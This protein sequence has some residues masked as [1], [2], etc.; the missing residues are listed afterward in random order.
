[1]SS[2]LDNYR[3]SIIKQRWINV[4]GS[5]YASL[6][7]QYQV[8]FVIIVCLVAFISYS[9]IK[10][11]VNYD[12]G[13]TFMTMAIRTIMIIVMV[14]LA[15]QCWN[16]LTPLKKALKQYE[17]NPTAQKSTGRNIDVTKEVDE[18]FSNIEKNKK[19]SN[20]IK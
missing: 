6:K 8:T 18:I 10:L 12:G 1:M 11:I 4:K 9:L 16:V 17:S 2:I 19:K 15:L 7:F 3:P 5:P 13:G 14:V 20:L